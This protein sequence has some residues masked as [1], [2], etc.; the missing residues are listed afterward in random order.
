MI[1]MVGVCVLFIV[2]NNARIR[3]ECC[4]SRIAQQ[5]RHQR[6][7]HIHAPHEE[8]RRRRIWFHGGIVMVNG[9]LNG[10][11]AHTISVSVI[12]HSAHIQVCRTAESRKSSFMD[13]SYIHIY[14]R[15]QNEYAMCECCEPF[16]PWRYDNIIKLCSSH[17]RV[18][19]MP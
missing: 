6:Q 18:E 10:M 3:T 12:V 19:Y 4:A 11:H 5:Q 1:L 2:R 15:Y 7:W 9:K 8:D 17:I 14:F 16:T 13:T